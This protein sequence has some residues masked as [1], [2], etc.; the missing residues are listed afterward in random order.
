MCVH[1][2]HVHTKY[3]MSVLRLLI[4]NYMCTSTY[5]YVYKIYK[6]YLITRLRLL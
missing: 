1:L 6:K 3:R 2:Q 4:T 5:M